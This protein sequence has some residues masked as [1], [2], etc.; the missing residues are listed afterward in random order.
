MRTKTISRSDQFR[1]VSC[2]HLTFG[3]ERG[4][5]FEFDYDE[6]LF[7]YQQCECDRDHFGIPPLECYP[8][9]VVGSN[10]SLCQGYDLKI[11]SNNFIFEVSITSPLEVEPC[12][13]EAY[14]VVGSSNCLGLKIKFSS[15]GPQVFSIKSGDPYGKNEPNLRMPSS[16]QLAFQCRQGS[17]GRLCSRCDCDVNSICYFAGAGNLCKPCGK[18]FEPKVYVPVSLAALVIVTAILSISFYLILASKRSLKDVKWQNLSIGKRFVYRLIHLSSLGQIT[19]MVTFVQIVIEVTHWDAYALSSWLKLI[20][21]ES[22]GIGLRCFFPF[23]SNPMALL[24]LR[25]FFPFGLIGIVCASIGFAEL[26]HRMKTRTADI[27]ISELESDF[28]AS[29]RLQE[30]SLLQG[31]PRYTKSSLIVY[32]ALA[33]ASSTSISIIK[34]F[35]FGT[36]MATFEYLFYSVQKST[37]KKYVQSVPWMLYGEAHTLQM[38]SIPFAVLFLLVIPFIF[39][40]MSWKLR[41]KISS[42]FVRLFFGSIFENFRNH[43]FWWEL[44]NVFRKLLVA[45]FLRGLSPNNSLQPVSTS[46]LLASLSIFTV[47]AKPWK[48]SY[49]NIFDSAGLM[50]I[51]FSL[52][53]G[54][55][56][57]LENSKV[58]AIS[59]LV[60]DIVYVLMNLGIIVWRTCYDETSYEK[61]W[62]LRFGVGANSINPVTDYGPPLMIRNEIDAQG[63]S[64]VSDNEDF[65]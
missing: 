4:N 46:F 48:M 51:V 62:N 30:V 63:F 64:K 16:A 14:R 42:P 29:E 53:S 61:E 31:E 50:L 45:L 23:L 17:S 10:I 6:K 7:D 22:E 18:V 55:L 20:N 65:E 43:L 52:A 1:G 59:F 13:H 24:L 26:F 33:L 3:T 34:F 58:V 32:P 57:M 49:E 2:T 15:D 8:C 47:V 28:E 27:T 38:L 41:H 5:T 44:V 36:T 21:G 39:V 12:I 60:M 9:S 54:R 19:I 40:L 25:L 35:Y 37:G 56:G 11:D